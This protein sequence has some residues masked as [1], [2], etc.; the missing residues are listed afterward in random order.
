MITHGYYLIVT[1]ILNIPNSKIEKFFFD[2]Y[3]NNLEFHIKIFLKVFFLFFLFYYFFLFF[4]I[5]KKNR[6]KFLMKIPIIVDVYL[7]LRS[8]ILI[9][10]FEK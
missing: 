6:E 1:H 8:I 10:H 7:F 9:Y 5:K 3:F 2:N 4:F